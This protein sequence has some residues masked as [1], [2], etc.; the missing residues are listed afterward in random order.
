MSL[1]CR[2]FNSRAV[3]SGVVSHVNSNM[4]NQIFMEDMVVCPIS[5]IVMCMEKLLERC[6]SKVC[7]D[8]LILKISPLIID[9]II[10]RGTRTRTRRLFGISHFRSKSN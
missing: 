8:Q 7:S 3:G 10:T 9:T 4:I 2:K 5:N 6:R 1:K